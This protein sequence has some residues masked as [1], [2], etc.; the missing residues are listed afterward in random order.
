M[1]SEISR[2]RSRIFFVVV[3]GVFAA[4]LL[5]NVAVVS[6]ILESEPTTPYVAS[7]EES[8][9][10]LI[11]ADFTGTM[12]DFEHHHIY[13]LADSPLFNSDGTVNQVTASALLYFLDRNLP[14]ASVPEYNEWATGEDKNF[15]FLETTAEDFSNIFLPDPTEPGESAAAVIRLFPAVA[16]M[17]GIE[18][19]HVSEFTNQWWKIVYR[20]T[21]EEDDVLTLWMMQ[22]YRLS[23][24]SG[25]YYPHMINRYDERYR[26]RTVQGNFGT[27]YRM[28]VNLSNTVVDDLCLL[29]EHDDCPNFYHENNYG[30][31]IVRANLL[32]D[33]DYVLRKI[34]I[35]DFIVTPENLPGQWQSS[36]FQTGTNTLQD[37]YTTNQFYIYNEPF[38]GSRDIQ[39][40]LGAT[41]LTWGR[42][43][44]FAI[45]N[46]KDGLSVGPYNGGWPHSRPV[47]TYTDQVWLPSDFEIRTVGHAFDSL[48]HTTMIENPHDRYTVLIPG[49]NQNRA[50]MRRGDR[51]GFWRLNGFDRGFDAFALGLPYNWDTGLV[52]MR[53]TT[54][55][56][57]GNANTIYHNGNRYESNA[58]Q[59]AGVRPGIHISLEQLR[60]SLDV[61]TMLT[62]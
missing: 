47:S 20:A 4:V 21:G 10:T 35:S 31:S 26:H 24:F 11:E 9:P 38:P 42:H 57:I 16:D 18:N 53:S 3:V 55:V 5:T 45:N 58:R 41:G 32:R 36:E 46:G 29:N 61:G 51:T 60:D 37:F 12:M 28:S 44:H 17:Y 6:P 52:W 62:Y 39:D 54:S 56:G 13:M 14:D 30:T 59:E 25:E 7:N 19:G 1:S 27:R 50:L 43:H 8:V 48:R 22:P 15:P 23:P 34:D 49:G 33:F 40:G 2:S